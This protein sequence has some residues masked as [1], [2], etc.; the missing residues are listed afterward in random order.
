MESLARV[1]CDID[2]E[3]LEKA[4]DFIS[5]K[6]L[7]VVKI[8][9]ADHDGLPAYGMGFW[10]DGYKCRARDYYSNSAY[11]RRVPL[12]AQRDVWFATC[13]EIATWT[14]KKLL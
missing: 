11:M 3:K 14:R 8:N 12:R 9:F 6:K 7:E 4:K 5:H 2:E 10:P 13:E 1:L